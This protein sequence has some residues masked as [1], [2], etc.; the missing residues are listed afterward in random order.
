MK[1]MGDDKKVRLPAST[2]GIMQYYDEYKSKIDISPYVVIALTI[3]VVIIVA[4]LHIIGP[5][6]L[7]F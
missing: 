7:G 6:I 1:N 3:I 4:I 2:G 5:K